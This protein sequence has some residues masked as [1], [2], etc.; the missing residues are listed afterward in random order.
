MTTEEKIQHFYRVSVDS[1]REEA[2][3]EM[4]GYREEQEALLEKYKEEKRRQAEM[5]QK[6]EQDIIR[7]QFRKKFSN[8]Q[9]Q[10][11]RRIS[12]QQN[13]CKMKLFAEVEEKL[14]AFR[15]SSAYP[16]YLVKKFKKAMDFAG[17]DDIRLM[18]SEGDRVLVSHVEKALGH[19]VSLEPDFGGGIRAVIETRNI[20]IDESFITLLEAER[21][22]FEWEGRMTQ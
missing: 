6:M 18:L 2:R 10:V 3:Q 21:A 12:G 16:E 22:E 7:K 9:M 20:L 17:E 19:P 13:E 1:A 4:E 14:A 5:D 15:Q 8:E 11:K